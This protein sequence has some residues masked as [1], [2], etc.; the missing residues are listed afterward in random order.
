MDHLIS[1]VRITELDVSGPVEFQNKRGI[2]RENT[3]GN[4]KVFLS[5]FSIS[6]NKPT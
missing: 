4:F 2:F 3:L 6:R 5:F 1:D